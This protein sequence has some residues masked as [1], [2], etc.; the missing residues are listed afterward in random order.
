MFKRK[1]DFWLSGSHCVALSFWLCLT[2]LA[3]TPERGMGGRV[4]NSPAPRRV[5]LVIGNSSYKDS[6]LT[7]PVNDA[8]D[9]AATL[10]GLG[11]D[12]LKH[13]NADQ[14]QMKEAIRQF[15][16]R[17]QRGGIGLFFFAGHGI[18]VKGINYLVP[19]GANINKET[20]VEFEAVEAGFVLAQMEAA[21]NQVNIVV[22]DACRNNPFARS[23]RSGARGLATI[24]AP[25]GSIIAYATAP[26]ST[27]SDGSGKNGLYTGALLK[28][29][30][31][32][33]RSLEEVFSATRDEVMRKTNDAQVPWEST[34]LRGRF[35][36]SADPAAAA[37]TATLDAESVEWQIVSNSKDA[38]DLQEFLQ[39]YPNGKFVAVARL[40]L[41]QLTQAA[42]ATPPPETSAA[43]W[44]VLVDKRVTL[45]ASED[46]T[47]TLIQVK[48][49]QELWLRASGQANLGEFGTSGPDGTTRADKKRPRADCQTGSL[50][51][52]IGNEIVCIGAERRWIATADGPLTLGLNES[53]PADN[54]GSMIVKVMIQ[55]LR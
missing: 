49:G 7:N 43:S 44:A 41:K 38:A 21:G 25:K 29:M 8:N 9:M 23:F 18:Q 33:G 47:E 28:H 5:A 6:P 42:V 39:R 51:A 36:F 22:L 45:Q 54:S 10:T 4:T 20:E 30:Q 35:S 32:P 26:G 12:V 50:L 17:M 15:G 31:V 46:W 16:E 24:D 55:E 34:S 53:T 13:L 14:R 2:V 1:T 48:R 11:F 27:A 19:V 52:R 40:R 3:Q 37:A